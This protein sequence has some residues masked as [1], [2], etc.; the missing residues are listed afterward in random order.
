MHSQVESAALKAQLDGMV[1]AGIIRH[2]IDAGKEA[3]QF[4]ARVVLVQKPDK[5]L[6][7]AIDFREVN[8]QTQAEPY[9]M[10]TTSTLMRRFSGARYFSIMDLTSGFW[11]VHMRKQ[12]CTKRDS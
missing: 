7:I 6:W 1:Q 3:T 11:N 10:P 12:T 5:T 4:A 8:E 9:I 2:V